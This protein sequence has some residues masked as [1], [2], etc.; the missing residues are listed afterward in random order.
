MG[1]AANDANDILTT[2]PTA[3]FAPTQTP[4][5][6]DKETDVIVVAWL[7]W[8]TKTV[9]RAALEQ[10]ERATTSPGSTTVP[11]KTKGLYI[12]W[13]RLD[14]TGVGVSSKKYKVLDSSW[15][16]TGGYVLQLSTPITKIDA[17]IA[18]VNGDSS[19]T[20]THL[21]QDIIFQIEK[22]ELKDGE[23]FSGKFFVKISKNQITD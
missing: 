13:R 15:K 21:H 11:I 18:H 22:K 3:I 23:D 4:Y 9:Y 19:T 10:D 2:A 12:S 6:I 17:D 14:A 16:G 8:K 5:R 1:V 20:E 7:Y